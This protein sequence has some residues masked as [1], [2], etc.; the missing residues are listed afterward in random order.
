MIDLLKNKNAKN[1]LLT[2]ILKSVIYFCWYLFAV[3]F[4]IFIYDYL[5][6]TKIFICLIFICVIYLFRNI[7][8][9]LHNKDASNNYQNFK[10]SIEL[11]YF[12]KIEKSNIYFNDIE[13]KNVGKMI[14]DFSYRATKTL[15]DIGE[16][17]IPLIL[18]LIILYHRLFQINVI[19]SILSIIYL[20]FLVIVRYKRIDVI[21]IHNYNDLLNNF[22]NNFNTIRK[23]RIFDFC[24]KKLDENKDNDMLILNKSND[25]NDIKF[26]NGM[27]LYMLI[28]LLMIFFNIKNKI[29]VIKLTCIPDIAKICETPSS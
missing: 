29:P 22:I 15:F 7:F 21:N 11:N 9:Y 17:V 2:I 24:L 16:V 8:K 25:E 14:L 18:G 10:H 12:S 23:L 26:S 5:S 27:I 4:S 6:D 19:I 13:L 3:V 20:I 1:C 28:I